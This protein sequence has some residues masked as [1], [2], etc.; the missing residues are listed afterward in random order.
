MC[1][2]ISSVRVVGQ[3]PTGRT[4][5]IAASHGFSLSSKS[6]VAPNFA[7]LKGKSAPL[8]GLVST[9]KKPLQVIAKKTKWPEAFEYLEDAQV[10]SYMQCYIVESRVCTIVP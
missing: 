8:T 5:R 2:K 6:S 4:N 10:K 7:Q 1:A 9:A 3:I